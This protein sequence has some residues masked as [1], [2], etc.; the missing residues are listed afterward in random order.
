MRS[1]VVGGGA[2]DELAPKTLSS[3]KGESA[4]GK[5]GVICIPKRSSSSRFLRSS[6]FLAFS[7]IFRLSYLALLICRSLS[8]RNC[9][10]VLAASALLASLAFFRHRPQM[11]S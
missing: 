4:I 3:P 6:S 1:G 5:P 10:L 9:S 7:R 11:N 8:F 2:G